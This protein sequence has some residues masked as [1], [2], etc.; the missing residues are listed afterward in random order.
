MNVN[1]V[2]SQ[3]LGNAMLP[4][5]QQAQSQLSNLEVESSTGEYADLGLQ[6]GNQ[7]GYELSL[8]NDDDLL[9]ALT[10][11]NGVTSTDLTAAQSALTSLLS[12]AQTAESGVTSWTSN[13]NFA[14][15]GA[16]LQTVGQSNLQQLIALA[17]TTASG[18]YVF[19][20]QNASTAPLD[21]YYASPT[22]TAKT[23][24]DN[25]FKSY[26]GFAVG[27]PQAANITA[28]QMQSFL[29]GPYANLFTS[30]AW[31]SNWSTASDNN[32]TSEIA[33]GQSVVT[34]TNTNTLG[35]QQ[36]AEGYTMLSEFGDSGLGAAAQQT[37]ASASLTLINQGVASVTTTQANLGV[38]QGAI[39]QANDYM[40]TQMTQVQSEIGKLDDVDAASVATQ[41]STLSTQLQTAYQLTAQIQKLS[42]AQYLPA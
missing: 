14:N 13:G 6:L 33:P 5:I 19:G 7:S 1:S 41:L 37:L 16:T 30:P 29:S 23:A 24:V 9:Q 4:A 36:L 10:T 35:W 42:L 20:G 27:S 18:Q 22:S 32:T 15:S 31:G 39:T 28:T 8:R 40:N 26:F 34:S 21:D 3:Y 12:S 11:A 25:A 38:S 17:N 2:S